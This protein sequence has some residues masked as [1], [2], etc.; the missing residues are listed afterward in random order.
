ME[1]KGRIKMDKVFMAIA[2]VLLSVVVAVTGYNVREIKRDVALVKQVAIMNINCETANKTL[3]PHAYYNYCI[4][5]K[6]GKGE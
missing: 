6:E 4:Y 5:K 1:R 2:L 3:D